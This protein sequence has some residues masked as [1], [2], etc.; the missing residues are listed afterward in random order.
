MMVESPELQTKTERL[1]RVNDQGKAMIIAR[2]S[3]VGFVS[4]AVM[5][6][7]RVAGVT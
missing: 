3:I 4:G 6:E 7:E 5:A 1:S 2:S